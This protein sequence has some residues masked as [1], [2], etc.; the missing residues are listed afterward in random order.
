MRNTQSYLHR[1]L[2][3]PSLMG[4]RTSFVSNKINV[5][6]CSGEIIHEH[7][8]HVTCCYDCSHLRSDKYGRMVLLGAVRK[9]V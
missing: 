1:F 4:Y 6:L 9:Y 7:I 5:C 2:V 3:L 8:S